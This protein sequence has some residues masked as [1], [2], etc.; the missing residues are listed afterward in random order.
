MIMEMPKLHDTELKGPEISLTAVIMGVFDV[1]NHIV[2]YNSRISLHLRTDPVH[3]YTKHLNDEPSSPEKSM[4]RFPPNENK[5]K[6]MRD[7]LPAELHFS[8]RA[9]QLWAVCPKHTS[10][11]VL[12][13]YYQHCHYEL[14]LLL[15]PGYREALPQSVSRFGMPQYGIDLTVDLSQGL[16]WD[17]RM[18]R[19]RT[20]TRRLRL[21]V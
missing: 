6:N 19:C 21:D 13:I 11:I 15:N 8:A 3:I 2:Q 14:Y 20:S 5:P 16:P 10:F 7:S 1:S 18:L 9:N 4:A 17:W 12:R